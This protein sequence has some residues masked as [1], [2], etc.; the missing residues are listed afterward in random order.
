MS[1][2]LPHY[3]NIAKK[4]K[5]Y[6]IDGRG[7]P[8]MF[9]LGGNVVTAEIDAKKALSRLGSTLERV[10]ADNADFDSFDSGHLSDA[11]DALAA[12]QR[13]RHDLLKTAD[14]LGLRQQ[15]AAV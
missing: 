14:D 7:E 11:V 15:T 12:Y 6:G 5:S 9:I 1:E 8:M 2:P 13:A 10:A 4:L 3:T